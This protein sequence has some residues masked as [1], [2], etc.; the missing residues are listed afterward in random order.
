MQK[1]QRE[2]N[3]RGVKSR[4]F[5]FESPALLDVEHQIASVEVL[6]DKE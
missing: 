2:Q 6:H 4:P 5:G 1:F 3:F